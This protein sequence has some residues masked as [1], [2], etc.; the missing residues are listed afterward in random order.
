MKVRIVDEVKMLLSYSGRTVRM[1]HHKDETVE[2]A[3]EIGRLLVSHGAA[4]EVK[5]RQRA[6]QPKGEER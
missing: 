2:V 1:S 4:V 3:D 6:V 5:P